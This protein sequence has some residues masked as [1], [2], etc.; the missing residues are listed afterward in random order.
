[1]IDNSKKFE[2]L[3]TK[4]KTFTYEG[5][6][7]TNS[8]NEFE[9]KYKF[10]IEGL[11]TFEPGFKIDKSTIKY[12]EGILDN[13]KNAIFHIGLIELISYWK[14]TCSPN[15][16]IKAGYI[17][18]EQINWFKKLYFYG[19]GELFYTNGINTNIDDFMNIS[20][21]S[22]ETY[23]DTINLKDDGYLIP[24]GGGK[25]SCVTLEMLKK[26]SDNYC[27]I[28]NPK[29][30][31]LAC[32]QT[33]GYDDSRIIKVQRRI[34]KNLL[35]LNAQGFINGHTPFSSMLAFLSSFI[36]DAIGKK[37]VALSNES[38]ANESNVEGEKINH[39]Y[40]KSL[41]F[42]NDFR[43]YKQKY[44][45]TNV[46]YFSF[47]RPLNELQIAKLFSKLENYHPIF[48]S[49]NVGSKGETWKWCCN[50]PK[51]LFVYIILS[52]F[53]YKEKLINIFGED[54]FTREDLLKT[55]V[56]LTGNGETKPFECVGTYEEV[57]FAISKTISKLQES[58]QEEEL[59]YLLKYYKE[60][61]KLSNLND[62]L[63]A[64][65]V[66][67]NNLTEEQN[68]ILKEAIFND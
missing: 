41:E 21:E 15:V 28:V 33:A 5:F 31:T 66:N 12:N 13:C 58:L 10:S 11:T 38:S 65:Y 19:L 64:R 44:L 62:D 45:D 1:M 49:C 67:E 48:K 52:P 26:E 16:I 42:E 27:L 7:I 46:E 40:S 30:V 6:S 68:K 25:D 43:E 20:C 55:F 23:I 18:Q 54:L 59:P 24:I 2:E 29:P 51:C 57:C 34:D 3:R 35:D 47:L 60:N 32:A 61:F 9:V 56:E 50:C 63:T 4:Y 53:L 17:N 22:N 37:Y 39:Q 36:A 8:K 14:A